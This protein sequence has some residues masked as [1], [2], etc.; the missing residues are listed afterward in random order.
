MTGFRLAILTPDREWFA[1]SAESVTAP[2]QNGEFGVL[3][4]HIPMIAGLKAG[5]VLV[6]ASG[7]QTQWFAVDGG[8]LGVDGNGVR[9]L[10]GRVVPCPT[11]ES[12]RRAVAA[13]AKEA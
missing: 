6:R 5:V 8:V 12:A 4:H 1:G 11:S 2:G 13:F 9:I 3:A 10:T 7:G